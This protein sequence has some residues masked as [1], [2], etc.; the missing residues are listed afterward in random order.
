MPFN[1]LTAQVPAAKKAVPYPS[2]VNA[3]QLAV[4]IADVRVGRIGLDLINKS[5]SS[6][7]VRYGTV[8]AAAATVTDFDLEIPPNVH[9][10]FLGIPPDTE[11][12]A[13]W[14]STNG[15]VKIVEW[16]ES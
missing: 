6:C 1:S 5:T 13:I 4:K 10:E 11:I 15:Y 14:N 2:K 7:Y 9:Y 3:S 16:K 12:N 8:A